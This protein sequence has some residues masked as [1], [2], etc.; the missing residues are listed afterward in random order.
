MSL[1]DNK[2]EINIVVYD[3]QSEHSNQLI[4]GK[5]LAFILLQK[6]VEKFKNVS[7]LT[8]GFLNFKLKHPNLSKLKFLINNLFKKTEKNLFFIVKR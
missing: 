4:S 7:F 2:Y 1:V 3:Q 8:G 6:L 5:S